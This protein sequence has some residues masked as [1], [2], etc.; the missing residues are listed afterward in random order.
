MLKAISVLKQALSPEPA[1]GCAAVQMKWKFCPK[2]MVLVTLSFT[3][4]DGTVRGVGT[5]SEPW[6]ELWDRGQDGKGR[7]RGGDR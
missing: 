7:F 2:M 6:E 5:E 3:P 4:A 1:H